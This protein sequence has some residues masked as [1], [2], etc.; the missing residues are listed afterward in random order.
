MFNL[1][2]KTD[3]DDREEMK[4]TIALFKPQGEQLKAEA[5][6]SRVGKQQ[7][8]LPALDCLMQQRQEEIPSLQAAAE[9]AREREEKLRAE[10][11]EALKVRQRPACELSLRFELV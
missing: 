9:K 1:F 3:A 4:K 5:D 10:A 11:E 2:S 6:A 7:K 8:L